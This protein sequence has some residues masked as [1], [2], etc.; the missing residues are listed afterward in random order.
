V[1][2]DWARHALIKHPEAEFLDEIQTKI[3]R[4]FLLA[5]HIHFYM[6]SFFALRLLFLQTH[7]TS[8]SFY[9]SVFVHVKEKGKENLIE[10]HTPF[11]PII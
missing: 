1:P 2:P 3:F 7:A 8:Y 11:F 9:S 6:Y 10:N 4:V 5:F